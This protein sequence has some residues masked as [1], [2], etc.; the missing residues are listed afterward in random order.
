MKC[1]GLYFRNSLPP[2]FNFNC[3]ICMCLRNKPTAKNLPK[4]FVNSWNP[5]SFSDSMKMWSGELFTDRSWERN[6]ECQKNDACPSIIGWPTFMLLACFQRY[7]LAL[8]MTGCHQLKLS[9]LKLSPPL[10]TQWR[11]FPAYKDT[12]RTQVSQNWLF[13][14]QHLF[15]NFFL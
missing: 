1:P 2:L 12:V 8:F 13:R 11:G 7:S 4:Y 15:L 3:N 5:Q 6:Q 9:P 14:A 10:Q